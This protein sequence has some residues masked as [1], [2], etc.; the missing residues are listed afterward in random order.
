MFGLFINTPDTQ[1][2]YATPRLLWLAGVGLV[3]WIGRLWI[4]TSRGEMDD[5][6]VIY[7]VRNRGSLTTVIGIVLIMLAA[8]FFR[9]PAVP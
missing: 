2:H 5:D 3:Y 6:P 7:A 9:L 4:K 1:S 8:H